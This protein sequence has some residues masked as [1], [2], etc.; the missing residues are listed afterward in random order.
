ME[1]LL[2]LAVVGEITVPIAVLALAGG[3]VDAMDGNGDTKVN[4]DGPPTTVVSTTTIPE[5]MYAE[6]KDGTFSDNPDF[7]KAC[8]SHKG[9]ARWLAPYVQCTSGDVLEL[10]KNADCGGK[11]G[12]VDRL[13]ADSEARAIAAI[14]STTST[15]TTTSATTR[16]TTTTSTTTSTT[17]R[18]TTTT[19]PT[20]RATTTTAAPLPPPTHAPVPAATCT[21]S[22]ANASPVQGASVT[23]N[24][25][26]SLPNASIVL[27]AHYKT[28][29]S[30]Y[31]GA[32]GPNGSGSVSFQTGRPTIG[33][34]VVVNVT[35]GANARCSTS[36]TPH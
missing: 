23:V 24:V 27:V 36:F 9:V 18:P 28:T 15:T 34:E 20:T 33:Y 32:T 35:V 21:A 14:T 30:T 26:S 22:M 5:G 2:G 7:S 6:C 11:K 31:S 16:T 1:P 25:Q 4:T 3:A 13:L 8:S 29:D 19:A 10:N 17:T 12:G